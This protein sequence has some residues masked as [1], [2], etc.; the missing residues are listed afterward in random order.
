MLN[1]FRVAVLNLLLIFRQ[2]LNIILIGN[3]KPSPCVTFSSS[4]FLVIEKKS[5]LDFFYSNIVEKLDYHGLRILRVKTEFSQVI[6]KIL[7]ASNLRE[8]I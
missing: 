8:R 3:D 2:G 4:E 1:R 7:K 6:W 5:F